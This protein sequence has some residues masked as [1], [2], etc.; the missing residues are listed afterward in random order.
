MPIYEWKGFDAAGKKAS[1]VLDADSPR[2][3]RLKAKRQKV[4]VTEV[5][6]MRGGK[7]VKAGKGAKGAKPAKG[8]RHYQVEVELP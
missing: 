6:E 4:L 2:D 8:K 5:V 7:R 1:G 3:A